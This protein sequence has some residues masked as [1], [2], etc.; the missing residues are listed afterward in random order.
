MPLQS[1]FTNA[2]L[3]DIESSHLLQQT[4]AALQANKF[5]QVKIYIYTILFIFLNSSVPLEN[6]FFLS[7]LFFFFVVV[8]K[9]PWQPLLGR[10]NEMEKQR[11]EIKELWKQEQN[12]MVSIIIVS[13]ICEHLKIM[14][15]LS[16][17]IPWEDAYLIL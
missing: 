4:I 16:A 9:C 12:K 1:L 13:S 17:Y 15:N 8:L 2:L 7:L 10:K 3:N 5:V 14:S 6:S 11:K